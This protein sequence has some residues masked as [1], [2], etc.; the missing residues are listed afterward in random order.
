MTSLRASRMDLITHLGT[1][2]FLNHAGK[3]VV[4]GTP[5]AGETHLSPE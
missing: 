4:L 3:V 2:A 5:G 1:R